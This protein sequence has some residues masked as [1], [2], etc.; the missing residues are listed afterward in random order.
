[1]NSN[2]ART[3][4]GIGIGLGM[5]AVAAAWWL[6]FAPTTRA[7]R[8]V[9]SAAPVAGAPGESLTAKPVDPP[10]AAAPN[11]EPTA[12]LNPPPAG[13]PPT[14]ETPGPTIPTPPPAAPRPPAATAPPPEVGVSPPDDAATSRDDAI[15]SSSSPGVEPPT[16]LTPLPSGISVLPPEQPSAGAFFEVLVDRNGVVE[17]VKLRDAG[18]PAERYSAALA[19]ARRW[20]F[21]PA[22][23][24]GGT[25]RY[26][27][28]IGL[29]Q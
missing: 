21:T 13:G 29:P 19:S 2:G 16:L 4:A 12:R 24:N 18:L 10:S 7:P 23:L 6:M 14:A 15:F 8:D 5:L 9:P 26:A 1:M 28:R 25:V 3:W 22:R 11:P 17:D 27:L 20:R